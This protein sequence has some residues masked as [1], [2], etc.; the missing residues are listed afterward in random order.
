[1]E[2]DV[3]YHLALGN[4]SHDLPE[5]FKDIKVK[6]GWEGIKER[7]AVSLRKLCLGH[8]R[9]FIPACTQQEVT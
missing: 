1:M 8:G 3:L 7:A 5:M 4:K 9:C 2:E 6:A